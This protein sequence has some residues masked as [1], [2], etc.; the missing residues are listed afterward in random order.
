V[1]S[2]LRTPIKILRD[3]RKRPDSIGEATE[4]HHTLDIERKIYVS[5]E[6]VEF[7]TRRQGVHVLTLIS[8]QLLR[9]LA[10]TSLAATRVSSPQFSNN[11]FTNPARVRSSVWYDLEDHPSP[12][13]ATK[14]I[15]PETQTKEQYDTWRDHSRA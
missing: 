5:D 2:R 14:E 15:D 6:K 11:P 12:G 3:R 9:S 1:K 13:A 8:H 4:F 7:C 10:Q